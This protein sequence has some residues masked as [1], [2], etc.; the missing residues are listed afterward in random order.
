MHIFCCIQVKWVIIAITDQGQSSKDL[1]SLGSV[2][3]DYTTR[4][5]LQISGK[6]LAKVIEIWNRR[7]RG[8]GWMSI[9]ALEPAGTTSYF[10]NPLAL[11][12]FWKLQLP[13]P[14]GKF[15]DWLDLDLPF[16]GKVSAPSSYENRD[17]RVSQVSQM[18][19]GT[20]G[21]LVQGGMYQLLLIHH[22]RSPFPLVSRSSWPA[23]SQRHS[24]TALCLTPMLCTTCLLLWDFFYSKTLT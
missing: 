2:A 24:L 3:L 11:K 9:N 7:W 16:R 21:C 18:T 10:I 5:A 12:F 23:A 14:W 19:E 22:L 1:T 4:L 20:A 15:C 8:G 17:S 13:P 6:V